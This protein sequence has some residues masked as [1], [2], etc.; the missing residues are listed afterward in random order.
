MGG[1]SDRYAA[2]LVVM[3]GL[4]AAGRVPGQQVKLVDRKPDPHGSPRPA[5][6]ARDV[7]LR[8]SLYLELAMPPEAKGRRGGSRVR[9]GAPATGG[10]RGRR[11]ASAGPALR[12]GCSGWLRPKQDLSGARSLAVYIEPGR[13]LE[14]AT[15]YTVRVLGRPRRGGAGRRPRTPAPGAS[16]PRRPRRSTR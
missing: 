1:R 5:R 9:V 14:P 12:R 8:T 7:P 11:A 6:E 4:G 13:P 16:P 15:R 2:F 10:G 3:L